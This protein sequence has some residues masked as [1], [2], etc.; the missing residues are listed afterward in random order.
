MRRYNWTGRIPALVLVLA[1]AGAL[2]FGCSPK[3]TAGGNNNNGNGKK[4]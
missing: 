2:V 4:T 1:A 3:S